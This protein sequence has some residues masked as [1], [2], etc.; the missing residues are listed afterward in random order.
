MCEC[1]DIFKENSLTRLCEP[2]GK[3]NFFSKKKKFKYYVKKVC[4]KKCLTCEE[5]GDICTSCNIN[6]EN[7]PLCTCIQDFEEDS[8]SL[9][10]LSST[11]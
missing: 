7:P 1:S 3:I 10:C 6:R 4:S 5:E 8:K 11:K 9:E 2:I